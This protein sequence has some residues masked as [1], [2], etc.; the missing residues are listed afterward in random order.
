MTADF[1]SFLRFAE[2][3]IG[4][5]DDVEHTWWNVRLLGNNAAQVV[6]TDEMLAH[7]DAPEAGKS[8]Q[9]KE[10]ETSQASRSLAPDPRSRQQCGHGQESGD[11]EDDVPGQE[12]SCHNPGC[13]I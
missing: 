8:D 5:G 7:R 2:E 4:R 11:N 12:V 13:K 10:T 6:G 3:M 1:P 9:R